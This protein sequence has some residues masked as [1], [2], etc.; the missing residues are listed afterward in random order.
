MRLNEILEASGSGPLYT[1]FKFKGRRGSTVNLLLKRMKERLEKNKPS[2]K[3]A[4][5]HI[6]SLA[7]W[8]KSL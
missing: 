7:H 1:Q 4:I 3:S 5:A 8:H 2:A 6:D